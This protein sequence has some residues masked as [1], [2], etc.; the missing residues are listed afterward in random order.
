ML[1]FHLKRPAAALA[2]LAAAATVAG[3]TACA[4]T[5]PPRL[6]SLPLPPASP[7]EAPSL[8]A[9]GSPAAAP[10]QVLAVRRIN[11]P[12]YLHSDKVRFRASD[13]VL[14]EWPGVAWAERLD[15]SMTEHLVLRLRQALPGWTVC[16]RACPPTA[17]SMS[18]TV[19]LMPLDYVRADGELRALARWQLVPRQLDAR[20]KA[21]QADTTG[22]GPGTN[23]SQPSSG[24]RSLK[25]PVK[26][27]NAEGQA[28][29]IA[30][31][32]EAL[33]QDIATGLRQTGATPQ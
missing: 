3:L 25:L 31:V 6:L 23:A 14:A 27:D 5:P 11:I 15:T 19:D 8:Q 28:S 9:I 18:L 1:A 32:L 24:E 10:L 22:N 13:S 20:A 29:A 16:E 33:T 2:G 4:S 26:P 30:Q 7:R 12:D 21:V 17:V